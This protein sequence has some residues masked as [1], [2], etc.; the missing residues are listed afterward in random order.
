MYGKWKY[1]EKYP[2]HKDG[3][4]KWSLKRVKTH[5]RIILHIYS[6]YDFIIL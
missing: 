3:E 6:F 2:P 5:E 1:T 4:G